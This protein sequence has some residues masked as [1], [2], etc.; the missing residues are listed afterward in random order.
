ML[1]SNNNLKKSDAGCDIWGEKRLEMAVYLRDNI[2]NKISND[3]FIENGTLLGAWRNGKFIAHDDDFDIGMLITSELEAVNIYKKIESQLMTSKYKCRLV[4]TYACKIEIFDEKYGKYILEEDKYR[5][6]DFHYV[7]LDLQFYLKLNKNKYERLYFI[8]P[9]KRVVDE[10]EL[11]PTTKIKLEKERFN[12]P[13]NILEFLKQIYG[14]L[15]QN[16]KYN[17]KT[18]FYE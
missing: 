4:N 14:S 2:L 17:S 5:S 8:N 16:A 11:I 12:A 7:T 9:I 10:K 15:E 3:W 6:S 18:G 13:N 1:T